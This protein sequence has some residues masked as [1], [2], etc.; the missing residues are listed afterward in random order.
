MF[1]MAAMPEIVVV[2]VVVICTAID[3]SSGKLRVETEVSHRKTRQR[4]LGSRCL[5]LSALGMCN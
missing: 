4:S 2:I 1:I 3:V 5:P